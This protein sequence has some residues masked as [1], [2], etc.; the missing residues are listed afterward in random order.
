MTISKNA[1]RQYPL[2]AK[3]DFSFASFTVLAQAEAAVELP[4]GAIVTGGY[5]AVTTAFDGGAGQT[6]TVAGGGASTAAIDADAGVS[7]NSLV[8]DGSQSADTVNVTLA[9][10]GALPIT[11]G[12]G[13]LVVEYIMADRSN[14][15]QG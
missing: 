5:L 2:T 8:L 13:H 3:V 14:E 4:S 1:D 10:A 12:A 11:A 7:H 9:F 6:L 15:N